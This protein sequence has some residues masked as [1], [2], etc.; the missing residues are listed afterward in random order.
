[1]RVYIGTKCHVCRHTVDDADTWL[2]V[3]DECRFG[4]VVTVGFMALTVLVFS[5]VFGHFLGV[6]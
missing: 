6:E 3:C 4:L 1:M 5:D 2:N